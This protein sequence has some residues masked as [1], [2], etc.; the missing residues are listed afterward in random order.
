[1]AK[2]K[3]VKNSK[4][5]ISSKISK[6]MKEGIRGKRVSQKQAVAVA[7]SMWRKKSKK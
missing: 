2:L 3:R 4:K 1:M 5:W 7:F 6:I